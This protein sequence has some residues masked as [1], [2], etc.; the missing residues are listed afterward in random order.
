[1]LYVQRRSFSKSLDWCPRNG[2]SDTPAVSLFGLL[3]SRY[4]QRSPFPMVIDRSNT[5]RL[6]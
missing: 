4:L 5:K 6:E 1:M 2:R 3:L